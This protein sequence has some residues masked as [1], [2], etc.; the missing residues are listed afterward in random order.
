M[1]IR[2]SVSAALRMTRLNCYIFYMA[3]L[4]V[5]VYILKKTDDL[6]Y[7]NESF[8]P[9]DLYLELSDDNE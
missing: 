5:K 4:A 1:C 7:D 2:D 6:C 8:M 9:Y 3:A